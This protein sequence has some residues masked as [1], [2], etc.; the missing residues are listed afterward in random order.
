MRN[1]PRDDW[2]ID[3]PKTQAAKT[4]I[5]WRQPCTSH[6][7]FS[8]PGVRPR[9]VPAHKPIKAAFIRRFLELIDQ[10]GENDDE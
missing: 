9:T 3:D 1:N 7:T 5:D 8:C 6:V 2:S 4:G 10:A